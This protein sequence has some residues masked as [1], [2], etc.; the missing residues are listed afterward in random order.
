VSFITSVATSAGSAQTTVA[1]NKTNP[2]AGVRVSGP[3]SSGTD[4][5][6]VALASVLGALDQGENDVHAGKRAHEHRPGT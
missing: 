1:P 5:V 2:N 3:I 4:V 6:P